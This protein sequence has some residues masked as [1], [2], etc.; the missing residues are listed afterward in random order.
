MPRTA[1]T[2]TGKRHHL[3]TTTRT[4]ASLP[5]LEYELV[6]VVAHNWGGDANI[7]TLLVE[8]SSDPDAELDVLLEDRGWVTVATVSDFLPSGGDFAY[9]TSRYCDVAGPWAL[10]RVSGLKAV[11]ADSIQARIDFIVTPWRD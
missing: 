2:I 7:G 11:E 8:G 10:L 3:A 9:E 5:A 1:D 4:L 6:R